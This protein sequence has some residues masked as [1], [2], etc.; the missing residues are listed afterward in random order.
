VQNKSNI[1]IWKIN[2]CQNKVTW[3]S[4]QRWYISWYQCFTYNSFCTESCIYSVVCRHAIHN[5]IG[6]QDRH[7]TA[8]ESVQDKSLDT[9]RLA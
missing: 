8:S 5:S 4:K 2:Y 9:E 3:F 6:K 7:L 1:Q